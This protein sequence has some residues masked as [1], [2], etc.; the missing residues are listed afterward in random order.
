M[1]IY[2]LHH[3]SIFRI[4]SIKSLRTLAIGGEHCNA[5]ARSR[6]RTLL[7]RGVRVYH[8]YGLTEMSVWQTMTRLDTRAL[9]AMPVLVRGHNLLSGQD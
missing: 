7:E 8:M 9:A 1:P 2:S 3:I 4:S 5:D 6:L